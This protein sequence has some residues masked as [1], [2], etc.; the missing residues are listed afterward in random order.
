M[1]LQVGQGSVTGSD[2]HLLLRGSGRGCVWWRCLGSSFCPPP[3]GVSLRCVG[4]VSRKQPKHADTACS[5]LGVRSPRLWEPSPE[6]P[7]APHMAPAAMLAP[8]SLQQ[9]AV[10]SARHRP[11]WPPPAPL[12]TAVGPCPSA[13]VA[14]SHWPRLPAG[15][16]PSITGFTSTFSRAL[17]CG[18][19]T[20][21]RP[22]R[23]ALARLLARAASSHWPKRKSIS[24]RPPPIGLSVCQ[25]L[26]PPRGGQP[27]GWLAE[28]PLNSPPAFS[29][30]RANQ[31][32]NKG[33]R[34]SLTGWAAPAG[35]G[36][37]PDI[38]SRRLSTPLR[39]ALL[40]RR[41]LW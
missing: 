6:R 36:C 11:A 29:R 25:S 22:A 41:A 19:T 24:N 35:V 16:A 3:L 37:A 21:R 18:S 23:A 30:L 4:Q 1:R 17:Q 40:V 28:L 31:H 13:P 20:L 34:R 32:P 2:Q 26:S 7:S 14:L 38:C 39:E 15:P 8:P 12:R 27:Y 10:R 9:G 33:E 5:V